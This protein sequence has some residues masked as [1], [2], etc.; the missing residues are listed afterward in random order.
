MTHDATLP[1]DP[2]SQRFVSRPVRRVGALLIIA[3]VGLAVVWV[4]W[5]PIIVP[6]SLL[7]LDHSNDLLGMGLVHVGYR[8]FGYPL[9]LATADFTARLLGTEPLALT[10]VLQRMLLVASVGVSMFVLRW[11]AIPAALLLLLPTAV[12]YTNFILTE[13]IAIPIAV[14]AAAASVALFQQHRQRITLIWIGVAAVA[15][16]VL[17]MIRLHYVV[18]TTGVLVAILIST[19]RREGRIHRWGVVAASAVALGTV[20]LVGSLALENLDENEVFFPSLG[21]DRWLFWASWETVVTQHRDDVAVA[22]PEIYLDG[23]PG[24]FTVMIDE[25]GGTFLERQA[26]FASAVDQIFEVTGASLTSERAKSFTGVI[27]GSRIDDLGPVLR[28]A[29]SRDSA[30]DPTRYI[31]QYGAV[32]PIDINKIALLYNAGHPPTAAL[33]IASRFPS[34]PT[35]YLGLLIAGL[36]P[37]TILVGLYL[38]QF[39]AA[40]VLALIGLGVI[41][42]YAAS[43]FLFLMD[44]LR[45]LLPGYLFAVIAVSGAAQLYWPTREPGIRRP[46]A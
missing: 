18:M 3:L 44:N 40:R 41:L 37:M 10:V 11:W 34:I 4:N 20:I 22:L 36:I 42:G 19:R 5:L 12:A 28:T 29:A 16:A 43:S 46:V 9:W 1:S 14:I 26:A 13:A 39:K 17:P 31:H 30:R 32:E 7:Y 27:T 6:D 33:S 25:S 2:E 8:Q 15:G 24:A 38:L 35:P 21:S 23:G 45:F